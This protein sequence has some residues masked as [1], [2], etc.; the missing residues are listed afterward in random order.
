M[1]DETKKLHQ[2]RLEHKKDGSTQT[3]D[4]DKEIMSYS[5]AAKKA[6]QYYA[7]T[8]AYARPS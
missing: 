2:L 3:D 7:T 8:S 5:E 1:E 6:A 4:N